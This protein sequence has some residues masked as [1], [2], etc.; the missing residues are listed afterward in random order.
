M[1]PRELV[2]QTWMKDDPS[3][4]FVMATI[5][6]ALLKCGAY[7]ET[8]FEPS[9]IIQESKSKNSYTQKDEVTELIG[10]AFYVKL[11]CPDQGEVVW[12]TQICDDPNYRVFGVLEGMISA[13][14]CDNLGCIGLGVVTAHPHVLK[15]FKKVY[16]RKRSQESEDEKFN[17]EVLRLAGHGNSDVFRNVEKKQTLVETKVY[18][19]HELCGDQYD[20]K[21]DGYEYF[22]FC[23]IQKSSTIQ[24]SIQKPTQRISQGVS[25]H[26]SP[27]AS[28]YTSPNG[29]PYT[30]T[31]S[32]SRTRSNG[33]PV[34]DRV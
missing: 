5:K 8:I 7:E 28:P 34:D 27:Y 32:I 14:L 26:S 2:S 10:H 24:E 17:D 23:K 6:A 1:S 9:T 4:G 11:M 20:D 25:P 18:L 3:C 19:R 21:K 12:F 31:R 29:S 33:T 15:A 13:V 30:F 16:E 22:S